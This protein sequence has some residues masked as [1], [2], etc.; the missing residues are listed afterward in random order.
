MDRLPGTAKHRPHATS[1][2]YRRS[3]VRLERPTLLAPLIAAE[4]LR[5]GM[6]WWTDTGQPGGCG[7]LRLMIR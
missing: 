2:P 3:A 4:A 7:T 5:R 1:V 6:A